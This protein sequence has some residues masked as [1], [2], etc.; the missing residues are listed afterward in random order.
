MI[1]DETHFLVQGNGSKF[2]QKSSDKKL[3]AAHI[4][5][6]V[7]QMLWGCVSYMGPEKC[8]PVQGMMNSVKYKSMLEQYLD[9]ELNKVES[10]D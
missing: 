2:V 9:T 8:V 7:K 1:S 5:Q 6:T 10:V 4:I 3:T